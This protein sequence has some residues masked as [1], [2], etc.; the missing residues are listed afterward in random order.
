[1]SSASILL[2]DDNPDIA[3]AIGIALRTRRPSVRYGERAGGGV[4]AARA[5]ALCAIL[6]DL[7]FRAGAV[8][9]RGGAG[10]PAPDRRRRSRRLRVVITAHSGIRIAV[11]AMQAG[12]RDFVMKP[13]RNADLIA[14]LEAAIEAAPRPRRPRR[15]MRRR[16]AASRRRPPL[17]GESAAMHALRDADPPRRAQPRRR[18]RVGTVRLGPQPRRG[19]AARRLSA[20]RCR[21]DHDRCARSAGVGEDRRRPPER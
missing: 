10:L 8:G 20:C 13:W 15:R 3:R 18:D 2:I 11:A 9:R 17:I 14:K 12:A 19:A 6:L 16:C 1:M 5:A 4:V 7:N 21:C